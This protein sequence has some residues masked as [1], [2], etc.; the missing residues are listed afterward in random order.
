MG[1]TWDAIVIGAGPNGLTAA[2]LLADQGWSTLVLEA[3]DEPGGAVRSEEVTQPGFVSDLFSAFYPLAVASPVLRSLDLERY[4]LV[5][6][7]APVVLAHPAPD[8]PTAVLSR[9]PEETARSLDEGVSGDGAAWIEL[10]ERWRPIE[11]PLLAALLSPFPPVRHGTRLLARL[12]G[13]ELLEFIRFGLLPVRRLGAET[14][15]GQGG[16]LLLAGSALHSDLAPEAAGSGFLG[17]LLAHIG[18]WHGWP[19]PAGGAGGL[20]AAL[21]HRLVDAGGEVRCSSPVRQVVLRD[22]RAGGVRLASGEVLHAR[23]AVVGAVVAPVLYRDLLPPGTLPGTFARDLDR[24]QR[25]S[26]TFKVDWA[27]SGPIPWADP[28]VGRAGTVHL[29]DSLDQLTMQSAELACGHLPSQPFVLLGQMTTA[30][31][32]RSPPG[33]ESAWAYSS[34]PQRVRGD[35]RG[36]LTGTWD[37]SESERYADRLEEHVERCAP[38]FRDR[39]IGRFVQPPPALERND[40]S[41]LGGDKSLGTA[42]LH[43][44]LV[45]RPVPGRGRAETP[46]PGLYL[47]S[48]S[49]HPGGG[50]HGACGANAA[51]AALAHHRLRLRRGLGARSA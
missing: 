36:Q 6:R 5:W 38:G 39:I 23:R 3:E 8:L 28:A 49:A 26:A 19:V 48:A 4:G 43:Q 21:V 47:G 25:G 27:L 40:G 14:F 7:H 17:W 9:D 34:V 22:G 31:P 30:D 2:N 51:R 20:T 11:E 45:L 50:V 41:L 10:M 29:I 37:R 35:A 13:R 44:Q 16:P 15:R 42:Q 18:Q 33:T 12:A 32:D 24:Y 46:V 1:G